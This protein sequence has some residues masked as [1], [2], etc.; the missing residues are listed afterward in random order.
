ASC[1]PATSG[2]PSP[3]RR[4]SPPPWSGSAG[5]PARRSSSTTGR[6]TCSVRAAPGCAPRSST[7]PPGPR[8]CG[9]SCPRT[10]CS[11]PPRAP[12]AAPAWLP[13]PPRRHRGPWLPWQQN[14]R[15]GRFRDGRAALGRWLRATGGDGSELDAEPPGRARALAG[16]PQPAQPLDEHRVGLER[17]GAVDQGVED[18]VVAGGTHV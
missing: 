1:T 6:T 9:R 11:D 7:C 5:L 10:A 8:P 17:G 12:P 3:T 16:G 14:A 13:W 2:W 18:L 15:P 4:T